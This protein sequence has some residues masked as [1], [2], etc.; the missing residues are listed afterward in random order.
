[1]L[2]AKPA[3]NQGWMYGC[4]FFDLDGHRWNILFMDYDK[5]KN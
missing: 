4:G 5:L 1:V 3:E 2:F